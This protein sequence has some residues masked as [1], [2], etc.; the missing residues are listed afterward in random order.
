MIDLISDF[1]AAGKPVGAICHG[2]WLLVEAE[3][4]RRAA[5]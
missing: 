5:R 4:L 2:P 3:L 1:A